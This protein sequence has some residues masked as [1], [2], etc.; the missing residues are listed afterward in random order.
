MKT[1]QNNTLRENWSNAGSWRGLDHG[2]GGMAV[3]RFQGQPTGHT[4]AIH[5]GECSSDLFGTNITKTTCQYVPDFQAVGIVSNCWLSSPSYI[6]NFELVWQMSGREFRVQI[7]RGLKAKDR[8][9]AILQVDHSRPL[10]G[11]KLVIA[12]A[13]AP[14]MIGSWICASQSFDSSITS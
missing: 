5:A 6:F 8:H 10:V 7:G 1:L 4:K 11:W 3:S 14:F 9:S 12:P 2:D 13:H